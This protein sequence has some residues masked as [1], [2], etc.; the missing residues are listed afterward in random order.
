MS[1]DHVAMVLKFESEPNEVFFLECTANAGV[2]IS[3]WSR[4]RLYKDEL[5]EQY[6]HVLTHLVYS[7]DIC[8]VKEMNIS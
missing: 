4:F 6:M 8:T 7:L 2:S 5:Y 1:T 3:R